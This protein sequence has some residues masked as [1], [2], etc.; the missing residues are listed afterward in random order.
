MKHLFNLLLIIFSLSCA[1]EQQRQQE[2]E[3]HWT[4][5]Y[6]ALKEGQISEIEETLGEENI[7]S[8]SHMY[9]YLAKNCSPMND[10][11]YRKKAEYLLSRKVPILEKKLTE[12]NHEENSFTQN[13][14][15]M[16]GPLVTSIKNGCF[17]MTKFFLDHLDSKDIAFASTNYFATSREVLIGTQGQNLNLEVMDKLLSN[18]LSRLLPITF[19]LLEATNRNE[20]FC[21]KGKEENCEAKTHLEVEQ[22]RTVDEALN[23]VSSK[24]CATN[25]LLEDKKDLMKGQLEFGRETGVGSPKTYDRHAQDAQYLMTKQNQYNQMLRETFKIELSP[26]DC[27]R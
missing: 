4:V 8:E 18:Y 7:Q 12:K 17:E 16:E 22:F 3:E 21:R 11:V 2:K 26:E 10:S 15:E 27:L 13:Y 14:F 9:N 20:A 6:K 5:I 19:C 25:S 24:Y 1:S 23:A